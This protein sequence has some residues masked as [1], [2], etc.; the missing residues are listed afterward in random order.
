MTSSL[1]SPSRLPSRSSWLRGCISAACVLLA[2]SGCSALRPKG[3]VARYMARPPVSATDAP[4][5]GAYALYQDPDDP[6]L[7]VVDLAAGDRVGFER[8]D[9]GDARS[10]YAVAGDEPP[11]PLD[12][13]RRYSWKRQPADPGDGAAS[14]PAARAQADAALDAA[15]RDYDRSERDLAAARRRLDSAQERADRYAPPQEAR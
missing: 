2:V 8:R 3:E 11:I 4:A 9:D 5:A 1:R 7:Y 14:S 12:S 15:R 13:G 6:P 10:V